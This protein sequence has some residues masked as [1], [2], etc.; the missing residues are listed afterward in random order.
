MSEANQT[1]VVAVVD[2]MFFASKI[3]QAAKQAGVSLE[4]AKNKGGLFD[5][6]TDSTP[7]LIVIDLNSKKLKPLELV[8][9]IKSS[10]ELKIVPIL[11]YLPHV[12]ELLKEEAISAGCDIVMPRS[13]FS[14]ELTSILKNYVK[15]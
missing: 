6:L 11:G 10:D 1:R 8:R 2:D 13:R 3:R 15:S 12:E 14:N 5:T 7:R 4:I 9:D